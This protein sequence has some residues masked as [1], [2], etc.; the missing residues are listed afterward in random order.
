MTQLVSGEGCHRLVLCSA[1]CDAAL[2]PSTPLFL[3]SQ[4]PLWQ[5]LYLFILKAS[6]VSRAQGFCRQ[7][8]LISLKWI[9]PDLLRPGQSSSHAEI[10][11]VKFLA[12][13][14][15]GQVAPALD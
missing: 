7:Y 10:I 1:L 4:A 5:S 2:G 6:K 15:K 13:G 12:A 3:V 9:I 11:V 8:L 14:E